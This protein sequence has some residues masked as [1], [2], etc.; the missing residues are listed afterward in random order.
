MQQL[1]INVPR[2][3]RSKFGYP[4]CFACVAAQL[5]TRARKYRC[6]IRL[7]VPRWCC[8]NAKLPGEAIRFLTFVETEIILSVDGVDGEDE[9]QA[10]TEIYH[11]LSQEFSQD[12]FTSAGFFHQHYMD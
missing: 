4:V 2:L 10:L 1:Y 12:S 5:V 7:S 8:I 6:D 3:E 9:E 11:F